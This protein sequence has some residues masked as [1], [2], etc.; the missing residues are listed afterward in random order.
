MGSL[1][2]ALLSLSDGQPG[3]LTPSSTVQQSHHPQSQYSKQGGL[4]PAAYSLLQPHGRTVSQARAHSPAR[5]CV[6]AQHIPAAPAAVVNL[7]GAGDTLTGGFAAA[8]VRGC[9]PQYALAVGIA[10]AHVSVQCKL[11]VPGPEQGLVFEAV[12]RAG[13]QLLQ[14][15]QVWEF[16]VHS[17]L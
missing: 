12:D 14:Q 2:A 11:N 16:P 8:L 13:R 1:G 17:M 6:R 7:S 15:Q 9:A 4:S 3:E 10:A 5:L